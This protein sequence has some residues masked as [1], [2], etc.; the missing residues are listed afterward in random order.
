[1]FILCAEVLSLML[2]KE[3]AIKG[4]DIKCKSYLQNQ[5]AGDTRIFLNESEISLKVK[6]GTLKKFYKM[7]GL[8][9]NQI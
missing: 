9:I 8:K 3:N 4:F 6:L 2:R 7:L 1:M 5:N